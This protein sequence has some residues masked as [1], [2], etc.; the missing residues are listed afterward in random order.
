M[1]SVGGMFRWGSQAF[2]RLQGVRL[3]RDINTV[4]LQGS[5]QPLTTSLFQKCSVEWDTTCLKTPGNICI[6][7][8]NCV[9]VN[10]CGVGTLLHLVGWG[11]DATKYPITDRA[12]LHDKESLA[13]NGNSAE[14]EQLLC[15]SLSVC[16][17]SWRYPLTKY[18][19][20]WFG[21]PHTSTL[22]SWEAEAQL[23]RPVTPSHNLQLLSTYT[24]ITIPYESHGMG[25]DYRAALILKELDWFPI[26]SNCGLG[27]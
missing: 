5:L 18:L 11:Q 10:V 19:P 14:A 7:C 8:H 12:A 27:F 1:S 25:R 21:S 2:W 22:A 15:F 26:S 17:I 24:N 20:S 16:P 9:C 4:R 6:S 13:P 23:A 3:C